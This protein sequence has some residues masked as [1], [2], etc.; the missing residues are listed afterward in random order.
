[1]WWHKYIFHPSGYLP[2]AGIA[3]IV[4]G[5]R[6]CLS[7]VDPRRV[8]MDSKLYALI[9]RHRANKMDSMLLQL[10]SWGTC[11]GIT[12]SRN[13]PHSGKWKHGEVEGLLDCTRSRAQS[14]Q[15]QLVS[16]V[17]LLKVFEP[18]H[19]F[20]EL[21]LGASLKARCQARTALVKGILRFGLRGFREATPLRASVAAAKM[22]AS[23]H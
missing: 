5:T 18:T 14:L 8:L 22:A 19:A 3:A 4:S 13:S 7:T 23:H 20:L 10:Q 1:M 16:H 17:G 9:V 21:L 2:I 15:I 11:H 12:T 6:F